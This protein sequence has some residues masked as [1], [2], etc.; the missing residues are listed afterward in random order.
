MCS[1]RHQLLPS[2]TAG[3]NVP[4][5]SCC[6]QLRAQPQPSRLPGPLHFQPCLALPPALGSGGTSPGVSG[7]AG[8]PGCSLQSAPRPSKRPGLKMMGL[9]LCLSSQLFSEGVQ[10]CRE[11][12]QLCPPA[13]VS[14]LLSSLGLTAPQVSVPVLEPGEGWIEAA[15][16]PPGAGHRAGHPRLALWPSLSAGGGLFPAEIALARSKGNAWAV[17][18]SHSPSSDP[19]PDLTF[20]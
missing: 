15:L 17:F 16:Q 12:P 13:W 8:S 4:L 14:S 19:Y 6:Q 10:E 18:S 1:I 7:C 20:P 11:V 2:A 3:L 5:G 9:P